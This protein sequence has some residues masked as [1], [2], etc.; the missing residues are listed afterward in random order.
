MICAAWETPRN[1]GTSV[2]RVGQKARVMGN[3]AEWEVD[4][5]FIDISNAWTG[6]RIII[7]DTAGYRRA[8][9][10]IAATGLEWDEV[11]PRCEEEGCDA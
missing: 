11:E 7:G 8:S 4:R 2:F 10:P 3:E 9:M 6:P 1:E 5:I